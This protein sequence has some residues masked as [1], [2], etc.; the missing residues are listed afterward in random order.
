M[1]FNFFFMVRRIIFVMSVIYLNGYPVLQVNLMLVQSL[2]FVVYLIVAKPFE[3]PKI[4]RIE[5][6]NELSILF[7][8]YPS[9]LFTGYFN[10][11]VDLQYKA[12]WAMII[13]IFGNIAVNLIFVVKENY[14][15]VK[16]LCRRLVWKVC[17][18]RR[19]VEV[20]KKEPAPPSMML[21]F[22]QNKSVSILF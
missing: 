14:R 10:A 13:M 18:W 3:D 21:D 19:V 4:N 16:Q 1:L 11:D 8:T 20:A 5:I 17:K 22:V 15:A 6:F 9:L 7:I 12:G 2:S